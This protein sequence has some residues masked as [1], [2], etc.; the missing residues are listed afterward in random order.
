VA[1]AKL[2]CASA[3]SFLKSKKYKVAAM[4]FTEVRT[5]ALLL[6]TLHAADI[7]SSSSSSSSSKS[8]LRRHYCCC[9]HLRLVRQVEAS[10]GADQHAFRLALKAPGW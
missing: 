7:S 6:A 4:K 10:A 3:L 2:K 8:G 1:T 9:N 5:H